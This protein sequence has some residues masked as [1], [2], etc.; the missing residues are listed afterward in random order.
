MR[1]MDRRTF[2]NQSLA[3]F[4]ATA[5]AAPASAQGRELKPIP[6][7][8]PPRSRRIIDM[9][10]HDWFRDDPQPEPEFAPM[11]NNSRPDAT[12]QINA[13]W[14]QF[15]YDLDVVDKACL[16][17]VAQGDVGKKGNDRIARLVKR[18]PERLIPFG[19]VNPIFEDALDE[20]KRAVEMLGMKGFKL[21]PIYQSFHPMDPRAARIYEQAQEWGI[22]LIFHTASTLLPH[23][24]RTFR[25]S[26]QT[27]SC[28]MTW[29][30]RFPN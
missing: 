2:L 19:S 10:V 7:V 13:T 18:W 11:L 15:E 20:F 6:L 3:G 28:S 26:G 24:R 12:Y 1:P 27:R 16:L 5:G 8:E 14:D 29:R 23:R 4:V 21:S 30:T 25:S 9:H 22:P 17:H